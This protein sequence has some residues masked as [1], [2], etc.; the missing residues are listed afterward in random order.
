[1][2]S[3]AAFVDQLV[4]FGLRLD[5]E[6]L[7]VPGVRRLEA[8]DSTVVVGDPVWCS[9]GSGRLFRFEA[10]A[11]AE[12]QMDDNLLDGDCCTLR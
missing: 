11:I 7:S 6:E 8:V 12:Y 10:G 3:A 4:G 1:M 5:G 2:S 9:A